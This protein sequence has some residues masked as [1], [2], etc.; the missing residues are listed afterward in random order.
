MFSKRQFAGYWEYLIDDAIFTSP[1]RADF[2]GAALIDREGHLVGIGSLFVMDAVTPG[3]RLPGNMFVPIDLLKPIL[4]E[5][6]A[7]GRAN[8]T[9]GDQFYG[10]SDV[11]KYDEAKQMV[12][13]EGRSG[14]PAHARRLDRGG[15]IIA[16]KIIYDRARDIINIEGGYSATGR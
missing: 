1:P 12:T 16:Q 3:E 9:W 8:V 15:E 4:E 2:G 6:I 14:G 5:M 10:S 7:T 11:I 13:L